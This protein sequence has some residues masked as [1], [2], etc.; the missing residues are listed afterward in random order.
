MSRQT[1]SPEQPPR[2]LTLATESTPVDLV[3]QTVGAVII[4]EVE[5]LLP[6]AVDDGEVEAL[7]QARVD[8]DV[9]GLAGREPTLESALFAV[10]AAASTRC[11]ICG[12]VFVVPFDFARVATCRDGGGA[13][14]GGEEGG[15]GGGLHFCDGEGRTRGEV[16]EA[17]VFVCWTN[18]SVDDG[19]SNRS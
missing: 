14:E 18:M 7:A 4:V 12:G 1:D 16:N 8:A 5:T 9:L 10:V 3:E 11:V 13:D 19:G 17:V 2:D 6:V 15:K